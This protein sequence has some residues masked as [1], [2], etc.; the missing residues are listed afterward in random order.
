MDVVVLNP[1]VTAARDREATIADWVAAYGDDVLKLAYFYLKDRQ[2]AEDVFQET[3]TR[4]FTQLDRFRG[5]AAAKTWLYRI[6]VNL[7]RDRLRSWSARNLL[8]LGADLLRRI[9]DGGGTEESALA[10]V[11]ADWLLRAVLQLPPEYR[12][13]VVLVYYEGMDLGDVAQALDLPP[14]TVR[15]RLH[16]ARGKLRQML[17]KG[18]WGQ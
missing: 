12:E 8:L 16:R 7:C 14:G 10:A 1:V 17:L 9:T 18:G 13:V 3:F 5:E 15:S 2:L 11:D 4:A 6:A